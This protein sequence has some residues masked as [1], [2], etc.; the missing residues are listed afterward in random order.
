LLIFLSIKSRIRKEI[1]EIEAVTMRIFHLDR[2]MKENI[3]DL[4]KLE[5]I[6]VKK[7]EDIARFSEKKESTSTVEGIV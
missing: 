3:I 5:G 4:M 1:T 2:L 6:V 7:S